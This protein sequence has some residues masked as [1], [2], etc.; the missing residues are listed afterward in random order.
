LILGETGVG[1]EYL[2]RAIHRD[3]PRRES[4]FV[5]VNCTALPEPLLES[6]LFGHAPG[7]F[8]GAARAHRGFFELAHRGVL[9]LDEIGE[10]A[11]PLQAK[12]LRVLQDRVVQPLGSER[13]FQ[14]DVRVLAATNRDLRTEM[15]AGRFR[16][17]LYYRLGV[18]SITVPPLRE[19]REDVPDLVASHLEHFRLA[20]GRPVRSVSDEAL[21]LLVDH[22]WPGNVREL[23][24]VV[25]RAV[26]LG[27]GDEIGLWDLPDLT[28]EGRAAE[29]GGPAPDEASQAELLERPLAE[30]R[31]ALV[32]RFERTYLDTALRACGGRVGAA[33]RRAGISERALFGKM[34]RYRLRKEDYR[35]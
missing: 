2:A 15:D 18:V 23:I 8:T 33:A 25:E 3:G 22:T 12:L 31:D 6:E 28:E 19:R 4:P 34:R 30:A 21:G 24:N 16:A 27:A 9:F 17:D 7:A 29:E 35:D 20:L 26:L 13:S 5:A 14:V 10:M 1:K 32:E 11:A